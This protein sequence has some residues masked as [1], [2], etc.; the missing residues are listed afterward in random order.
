MHN[1]NYALSASE[2]P[3][4][5]RFENYELLFDEQGQAIELG[6]GAMG[7]TYKAIDTSLHRLAALKVISPRCIR[8]AEF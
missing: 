3:L 6:R 2:P 1:N 4:C 5:R 7:V 8:Y